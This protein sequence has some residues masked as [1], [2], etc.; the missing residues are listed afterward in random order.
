M[1]DTVSKEQRSW[2][3]SRIRSRD[4][5]P[6]V[7]VRGGLFRQGFRFRINDRRYPGRPDVVPFDADIYWRMK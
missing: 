5:K 3:M 2:N 7:K 4:T 6:E 1:A